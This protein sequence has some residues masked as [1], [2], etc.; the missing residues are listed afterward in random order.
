MKQVKKESLSERMVTEIEKSGLSV[1]SVLLMALTQA[2]LGFLG[3][4]AYEVKHPVLSF[5]CWW[6]LFWGSFTVIVISR[7]PNIKNILDKL[8]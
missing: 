5:L 8:E 2:V 4:H 7:A 3:I 6:C 1:T